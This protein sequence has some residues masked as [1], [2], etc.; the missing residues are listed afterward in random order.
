MLT[1][2]RSCVP[3]RCLM[4]VS[5]AIAVRSVLSRGVLIEADA[6]GFASAEVPQS[7][8]E[9]STVRRIGGRR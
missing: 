1:Q 3:A 8:E 7:G 5:S 2:D 6:L 9:K 4:R